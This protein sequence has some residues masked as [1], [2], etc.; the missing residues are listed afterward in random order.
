MPPARRFPPPWTLDEH[1]DACFIVRDATGQALGSTSSTTANHWFPAHAPSIG[2]VEYPFA[3]HR[4][5]LARQVP[6][7]AVLLQSVNHVVSDAVAFLF[8]KPLAQSSHQLAHPHERD[9]NPACGL[10]FMR[11]ASSDE[12]IAVPV[13]V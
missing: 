5:Q 10:P 11:S 8:A 4:R 12:R 1:N 2:G 9:R 6:R 3:G 13:A 7:I